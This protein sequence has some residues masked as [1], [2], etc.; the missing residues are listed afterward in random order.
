MS[1]KRSPGKETGNV[2]R[3][4]IICPSVDRMEESVSRTNPYDHI[5]PKKL[6]DFTEKDLKSAF[7]LSIIKIVVSTTQC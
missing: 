3:K 1:G 4:G 6:A 7:K 2:N 5:F